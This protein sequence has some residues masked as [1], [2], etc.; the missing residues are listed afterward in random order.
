[1]SNDSFFAPKNSWYINNAIGEACHMDAP[2]GGGG[3]GKF[4]LAGSLG[5]MLKMSS[6][7]NQV[8]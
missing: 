8:A 5:I 3:P 4:V 6:D 2:A 1:M 7:V